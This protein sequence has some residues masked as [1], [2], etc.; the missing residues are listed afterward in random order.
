MKTLAIIPARGGS[1]GIPRK[2]LADVCGKP[3]IQFS[4]ETGAELAAMGAITKCIVSTDDREIAGVAKALGAEVPFMRPEAAA[5]DTAK[6]VSYVLHAID[7]FESKDEPFDAVLLLQPTSPLRN[8]EAIGEAIELFECSDADSMISCYQEDYINELV[9]YERAD[10]GRLIPKSAM[11]NQGVRRQEIKPILVRN[12]ALYMT[13]VPFIK[14]QLKLVCD[15]PMLMEM[16]KYDSVD[17]DT[18]SDLKLLRAII[19]YEDRNTG[20]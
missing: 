2:N 6:A 10:K 19:S 15:N 11:H 20:A 18:E 17:I 12:G 13:R 5:T 1:K 4:I 16:S 3:L 9:S 8:A 14:K 7:F